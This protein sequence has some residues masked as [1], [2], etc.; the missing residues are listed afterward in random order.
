MNALKHCFDVKQ[1]GIDTENFV[2]KKTP[3]AVRVTV[4]CNKKTVVC[5]LL[6]YTKEQ[7]RH[8]KKYCIQ[9]SDMI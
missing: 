5:C 3:A 7:N 9:F 8:S 6:F 1:L 4:N 2:E